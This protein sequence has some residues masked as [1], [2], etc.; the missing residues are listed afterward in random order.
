MSLCITGLRLDDVA[1]RSAS[2]RVHGKG[3][4]ERAMPLWKT[5]ATALRAWLAVRGTVPV[6]ELFVNGRGEA[7]S[8]WGFAYLLKQ[9]A[10]A[11]SQQCPS[12][13]S[14]RIS[15]HVFRHTC[16]NIV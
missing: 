5:T 4:R 3:R 2:I 9:H 10:Q 12:F 11:A 15:P 8:R 6:P 14:K 1:P 7:M 13:F 16:A